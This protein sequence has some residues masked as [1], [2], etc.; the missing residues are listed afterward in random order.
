MVDT[1][2]YSEF[3]FNGRVY[4]TFSD[5]EFV[6]SAEMRNYSIPCAVIPNSPI[7]G[8]PSAL[9]MPGRSGLRLAQDCACSLL[10]EICARWHDIDGG[11]LAKL[12]LG[13]LTFSKYDE[14]PIAAIAAHIDLAE[15]GAQN[16]LRLYEPLPIDDAPDGYPLLFIRELEDDE[17]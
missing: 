4:A 17:S 16:P 5:H 11:N 10:S 13:T 14:S 12:I 1:K 2:K 15:R 8:M 6:A 3:N 7:P 9:I